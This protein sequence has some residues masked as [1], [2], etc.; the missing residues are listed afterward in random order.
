MPPGRFRALDRHNV[1]WKHLALVSWAKLALTAGAGE[2]TSVATAY[3]EAPKAPPHGWRLLQ[4]RFELAGSVVSQVPRGWA[5]SRH[6]YSSGIPGV[7][8]V[9]FPPRLHQSARSVAQAIDVGVNAAGID[10]AWFSSPHEGVQALRSDPLEVYPATIAHVQPGNLPLLAARS[11]RL[12]GRSRFVACVTYWETKRVK[13][14]HA[15]GVPSLDE[16]WTISAFCQESCA[17]HTRQP[18]RVLP[19]PVSVQA[20]RAGVWRDHLGLTN[21]FVFSFQFDMASTTQRKNPQAVIEAFVR[22]FPKPGPETVLII[23]T[24]NTT[25]FPEE[26]LQL[27]AQVAARPDI[28]LIDDF[29]PEEINNA[30]YQDIDCYVSLHR[31]EGFGIGMARAMASGTAVIATGYSG[32]LDFMTSG[33]A[34]LVPYRIVPV[35]SNP[36]Y[37]RR[38]AWAEPDLD[39]AADA[40]R[41][42]REDDVMRKALG[43]RAAAALA[44]RTNEALGRWIQ[45]HIPSGA[46]P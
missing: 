39:F 23:K 14:L 46:K 12:F 21:E 42:V 43:E 37:P 31:A 4:R 7:N 16:I 2:G 26:Y 11:P 3:D 6:Q 44:P 24:M 8:L 35:G 20:E 34:V 9:S 30:Y 17:D 41:Q 15:A 19:F 10:H 36:V 28:R 5:R 29:W 45:E 33:S 1:L 25:W 38:S 32:N 13:K 22:A 18:V 27:Q 40:M